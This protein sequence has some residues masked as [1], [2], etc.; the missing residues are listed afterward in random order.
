[1]PCGP[2]EYSIDRFLI[3][4]SG[5]TLHRS[6]YLSQQ[7][8]LIALGHFLILMKFLIA[9]GHGKGQKWQKDA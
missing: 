4:W 6:I 3:S 8:K 2:K 5:S 7:L 9:L 1:M